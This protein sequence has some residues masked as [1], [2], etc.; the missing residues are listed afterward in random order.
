MNWRLWG[1]VFRCCRCCCRRIRHLPLTDSWFWMNG[2]A[3]SRVWLT[4]ARFQLPS[5]KKS[6]KVSRV[7][8]PGSFDWP[9]GLNGGT[10]SFLR[11]PPWVPPDS[12]LK[13]ATLRH[14][15]NPNRATQRNT[16]LNACLVQT[17]GSTD[18]PI[19]NPTFSSVLRTGFFFSSHFVAAQRNDGRRWPRNHLGL[20]RASLPK[21]NTTYGQTNI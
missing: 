11:L 1:G 21:S 3:S 19:Q 16:A 17:D 4:D 6:E 18:P 7:Q 14:Q 10:P 15:S 13:H 5:G 9:D 8:V 2:R 20:S 12:H